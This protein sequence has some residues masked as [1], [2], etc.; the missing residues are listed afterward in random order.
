M[1]AKH[2]E[3]IRETQLANGAKGFID[4]FNYPQRES[5]SFASTK[6]TRPFNDESVPHPVLVEPFG[7]QDPWLSWTPDQLAEL[8]ATAL[9]NEFIKGRRLPGMRRPELDRNTSF[10]AR[11][12]VDLEAA[13]EPS[14]R[15]VAPCK[16]FEVERRKRRMSAHNVRCVAA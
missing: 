11:R 12:L 9:R 15:A 3:K 14:F 10:R 2:D 8:C 13:E 5:K 4:Q 6:L 7:L 16:Y 1:N